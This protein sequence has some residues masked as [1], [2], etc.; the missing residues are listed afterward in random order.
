[1]L[2]NPDQVIRNAGYINISVGACVRRRIFPRHGL[3]LSEMVTAN[4]DC[5]YKNKLIV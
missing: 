1:M 2:G 3:R 4:E 5:P